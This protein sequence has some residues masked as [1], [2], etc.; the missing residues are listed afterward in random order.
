VGPPAH[1]RT[2]LVFDPLI[3]ISA[4]ITAIPVDDADKP[5]HATYLKPFVRPYSKEEIR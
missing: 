4:T 2:L 5:A 1:R 3:F